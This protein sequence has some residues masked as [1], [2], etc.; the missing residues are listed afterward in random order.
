VARASHEDEGPAFPVGKRGLVNL[1]VDTN[2]SVPSPPADRVGAQF[3]AQLHF[4]GEIDAGMPWDAPERPAEAVRT[5]ARP[6]RVDCSEVTFFGAAGLSMLA[7]LTQAAPGGRLADLVASPEAELVTGVHPGRHLHQRLPPPPPTCHRTTLRF[8]RRRGPSRDA[9]EA[10][11]PV[12]EP[13][14]LEPLTPCLQSRCATNCAMA[15][16]DHPWR[17]VRRDGAYSTVSVIS[18]HRSRSARS[19]LTLRHAR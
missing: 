9:E 18:A 7:V 4:V 5:S 19:S 3:I 16:G 6:V 1:P 17:V 11:R 2:H 14:G 12:V 15:P 10:L 13:R 8:P